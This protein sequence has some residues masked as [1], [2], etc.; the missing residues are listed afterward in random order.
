MKKITSFFQKCNFLVLLLAAVLLASLIEI[1]L[2]NFHSFSQKFSDVPRV[3]I[4]LSAYEGYNGE[5]LPL[6]PENPTVAFNN[7][8]VPVHSLTVQTAGPAQVLSGNIGICDEANAYSTMGAG[9]FQVN[10]GG[11]ESVFTVR[12]NSR[13]DLSR[14]RITFTDELSDPVFLTSVVLNEQLPVQIHAL[15]L[16][17]MAGLLF[18]LLA[19]LRYELYKKDYCPEEKKHHFLNV[20][21]CGLC[22]LVSLGILY[23]TSP[24]HV[25]LKSYPTPEEV[26]SPEMIV[27]AYMQ[28]L[29]AFEKGQLELDLDVNPELEAL[30]NVY[31]KG[32][33]D[34]KGVS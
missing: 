27:D 16:A 20:L 9:S 21:V 28:Q 22:L 26:R 6:L 1:F 31:D 15:R 11:H 2:F 18:L 24:D 23:G 13:G 10:P 17:L 33:R 34:K 14:L 3:E 25:Y 29:D 12:I 30:D 8:N 32:E 5:A 19:V 7:L 4:D